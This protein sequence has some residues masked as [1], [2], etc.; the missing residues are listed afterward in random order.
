VNYLMTELDFLPA[1][2]CNV[3]IRTDVADK[4]CRKYTVDLAFLRG[5]PS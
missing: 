5:G 3:R 4:T 2:S 1:G